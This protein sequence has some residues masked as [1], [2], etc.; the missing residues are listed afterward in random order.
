[1]DNI[2]PKDWVGWPSEGQ[3]LE[4]STKADG[5]FHYAATAL[6][7]IEEQI[8]Q[9]EK[10]CQSWVFED[11][12]DMGIGQLGNLYSR[13]LTSFENINN[14]ALLPRD[15][16]RR[17]HR[18][19]GFKHLIGTILVLYRPLTMHQIMALLIDIPDNQLD[20]KKSLR[21]LRSV[22]V[23]SIATPFEEAT[24]QMHKSFRDYIMDAALPEFR[25][26]TG[27]A[28][29]M[30]ARSCLEIIVKRGSQQ[31]VIANYS[32]RHWHNHLQKAV[33]GGATCEDERIWELLGQMVEERVISIWA[34]SDLGDLFVNVANA[35]WRLL[36]VRS[37]R[38]GES[39]KTDNIAATWQ[40]REDATNFK[41]I[42]R[43]KSA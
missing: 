1:M 43:S 9:Y 39:E 34:T 23:P 36:K 38:G 20:V 12:T 33:E 24:P 5:L 28:H 6:Q 21:Q 16:Q 10:T 8:D 41:H 15:Q 30:T 32:V 17:R 31:D 26:H 29:F 13:I 40:Y 4:L 22:L 35:G 2:T 27:E 37:K 7:W 18:L 3:L 11:L 25:I 42:T 14:P 19:Q